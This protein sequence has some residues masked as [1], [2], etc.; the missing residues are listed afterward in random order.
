MELREKT[1]FILEQMRLLIAVAQLKGSQQHKG[2]D[3]LTG[4]DSEWIRAKAT[5][6]KIDE[7]YLCELYD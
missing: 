7:K 6:R 4:G 5:G 2:R 3:S 1:E